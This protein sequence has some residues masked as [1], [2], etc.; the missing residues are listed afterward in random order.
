MLLSATNAYTGATTISNGT[1]LVNGVVSNGAVK[2]VSGATLGGNGTI[3]GTVTNLAGSFLLPG[4]AVGTIGKLTLG[5]TLTLSGAYLAFDCTS[6]GTPGTDY[7]QIAVAG[8]LAMSGSNVIQPNAPSGS[9]AEGTY[10]LM[11]FA[12][13][14]TST[15]TFPNGTTV[16]AFGE[17]TIRLNNGTTSLTMTAQFPVGSVY[18][19]R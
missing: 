13:S 10:T 12:T 4:G 18:K 3:H 15:F 19:I 5:S 7:D 6:A 8:A 14:P 1:L 11:T 17:V 16:M 9:I 2:V